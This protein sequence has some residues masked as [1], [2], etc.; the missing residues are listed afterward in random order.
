M[1]QAKTEKPEW[2]KMKPAE[3][4]KLVLE[5]HKQGNTPAKIGLILRDQHGIPKV[6]VLGKRLT[7]ILADNKITVNP[8]KDL[9]AKKMKNLEVHITKNKHDYP[10][11]RSLTKKLW[12]A[13]KFN[14]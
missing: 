9:L 11:Q 6:K 10:A 7:K 3:V 13:K 2:V 1:E 4:E 14:E 8:E 5:L 12:I